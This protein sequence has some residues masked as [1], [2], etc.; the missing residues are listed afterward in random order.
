MTELRPIQHQVVKGSYSHVHDRQNRADR[1]IAELSYLIGDD[2][3]ERL[4]SSIRCPTWTSMR[5]FQQ[6]QAF[7][8]AQFPETYIHADLAQ[9][10][11]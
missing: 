11:A 4:Q 1:G 10:S 8:H 2:K 9:R 7:D 5:A 6:S 3:A